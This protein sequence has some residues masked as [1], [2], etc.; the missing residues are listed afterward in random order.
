M[1]IDKNKKA[2]VT[3]KNSFGTKKSKIS[4][5]DNL[6]L[7]CSIFAKNKKAITDV[8]VV[9]V[10]VVVLILIALFVFAGKARV[11]NSML[12]K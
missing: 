2:A 12:G 7:S 11:F 10:L 4:C 1:K 5:T 8:T 6:Q 3:H 9:I